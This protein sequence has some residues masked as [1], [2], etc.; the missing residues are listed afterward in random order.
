GSFVQVGVGAC[1][2]SYTQDD[3][4]VAVQPALFK[5]GGNPN[6]DPICDQYVLLQN[7]PK[8]VHAR[9]TEKC[10]DCAENQV[11]GTKAIWKAL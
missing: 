6:L 2:K 4:V 5:T 11:V 10:H 7:G 8:T 9:I 1:G 3:F